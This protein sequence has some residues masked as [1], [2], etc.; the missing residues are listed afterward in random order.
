MWFLFFDRYPQVAV[1]HGNQLCTL[2]G[3]RRTQHRP[4]HLLR[5]SHLPDFRTVR[6][7]PRT[8]PPLCALTKWRSQPSS[9]WTS[10]LGS[11]LVSGLVEPATLSPHDGFHHYEF[12]L[13]R[14]TPCPAA[15]PGQPFDLE[16]AA[17]ASS[18][19]TPKG[20]WGECPRANRIPAS[21]RWSRC[22][23]SW[24]TSG[25]ETSRP[26]RPTSLEYVERMS[27]SYQALQ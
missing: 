3:R 2:G 13:V 19:S 15:L 7:S 25:S 10:T 6:G 8:K 9:H 24:A 11:H 27:R 22:T 5:R 20:S 4:A 12:R 21:P 14:G 26:P 17:C 18:S 16:Y 23:L 1:F